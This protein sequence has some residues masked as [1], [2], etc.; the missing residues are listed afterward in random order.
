[1]NIEYRCEKL[2]D[3][4][5]LKFYGEIAIFQEIEFK[6]TFQ[7]YQEYDTIILDLSELDYID[8]TGINV[9][10]QWSKKKKIY[11]LNSRQNTLSPL[12]KIL[13]LNH[14]VDVY[15]SL[16]DIYKDLKINHEEN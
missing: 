14:V 13:N 10:V 4:V 11:I 2:L 8:S 3:L 15:E 9:I 6:K 12:L 7:A 1:M 5:V 16:G